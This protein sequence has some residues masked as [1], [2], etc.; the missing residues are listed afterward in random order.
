MPKIPAEQRKPRRPAS[1]AQGE[2]ARV[3]LLDAAEALFADHGYFGVS[4]RDIT[5]RAGLRLAA[6]NYHFESK[7]GLFAK[8][9][10]RRASMLNDGRRAC[11]KA[12]LDQL[13]DQPADPRAH[14]RAVVRAFYL[15]LLEYHQSGDEGWRSYGR[16]ISHVAVSRLWIRSHVSPLYDEV[17][18]EFMNELLALAPKADRRKALHC[19]Q[20]MIAL[21]LYVFAD[22]DRE[23]TLSQGS[24]TSG[25]LAP[26]AE[27]MEDFCVEGIMRL[28]GLDPD[29]A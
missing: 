27:S 28:L 18:G 21:Q 26:I 16:L 11:L 6:V 22:N 4:V 17:C 14:V 12:G 25:D 2:A 1:N 29:G 23:E 3:Q 20:F 10:E 19:I 5:D 8:V 13:R 24:F 9:L 7:E 15:P